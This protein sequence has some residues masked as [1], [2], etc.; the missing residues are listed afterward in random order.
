MGLKVAKMWRNG[1]QAHCSRGLA[2]ERRLLQPQALRSSADVVHHRVNGGQEQA[3]PLAVPRTSLTG[4]RV[5]SGFQRRLP[6]VQLID[7]AYDGYSTS[8]VPAPTCSSGSV[9]GRERNLS[10]EV[11]KASPALMTS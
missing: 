7:A 4:C 2:G 9:T 5:V 1:A 3:G 10:V 6:I 11:D 8:E